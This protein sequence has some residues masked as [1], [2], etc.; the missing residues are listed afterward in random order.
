MFGGSLDP[1]VVQVELQIDPAASKR[2]KDAEKK[3]KQKAR[4]KR[5]SKSKPADE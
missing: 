1:A 3:R 4:R 5:R 2:L